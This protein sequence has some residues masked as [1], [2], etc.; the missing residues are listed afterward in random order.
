MLLELLPLISDGHSISHKAITFL[1]RHVFLDVSLSR[2]DFE[3]CKELVAVYFLVLRLLQ[4]TALVVNMADP[5][6]IVCRYLL[7]LLLQPGLQIRRL[8][9]YRL[10]SPR[11]IFNL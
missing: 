1:K 4:N 5:L 8:G 3:S 9:V 7:S 6:A 2:H 11:V 10:V